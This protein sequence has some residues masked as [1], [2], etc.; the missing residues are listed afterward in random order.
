MHKNPQS[1][2]TGSNWLR[3]LAL[4][5]PLALMLMAGNALALKPAPVDRDQD[6]DHRGHKDGTVIEKEKG[7]GMYEFTVDR[8]DGSS[9]QLASNRGNVLLIVNTASECGLTPQYEKLQTLHERYAARGL[10]IMGFPCNEFGG[11]EPGSAEQIQTF[12]SAN[13]GVE[14]PMYAK[15]KVLGDGAAPLFKWLKTNSPEGK[16]NEIAWNFNKFL[17]DGEGHV[18]DRFEPKVD[19]LSPEVIARIEEL[20]PAK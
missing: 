19:P 4:A 10:K 7:S 1:W 16:Q 14:F 6:M 15:V 5:A 8:L 3:P 17:V 2:R 12:C 11:Q 18:V 9:E 20:L 13:Y